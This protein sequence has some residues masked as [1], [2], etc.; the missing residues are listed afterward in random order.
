MKRI[1]H[2]LSFILIIITL[3]CSAN[4]DYSL[5]NTAK[6]HFVLLDDQ[7]QS[8]VTI[9]TLAFKEKWQWIGV[10]QKQDSTTTN[11][12]TSYNY[13]LDDKKILWALDV[14]H[15]QNSLIIDNKLSSTQAVPLTYIALA[16]NPSDSLKN[17]YIVVTDN[18]KKTT[19]LTIPLKVK[20]TKK[21]TKMELFNSEKEKK[22]T[23]LFPSPINIHH[24]QSSR[25]KLTG[26]S[27]T[28]TQPQQHSIKLLAE[29][30]I[31]F[32]K[33]NNDVPQQTKHANWFPFSPK[34]SNKKGEIGLQDWL[35]APNHVLQQ[36]GNGVKENNKSYKAWGTNVEYIHV[37]P[38]RKTA[39]KRTAFFAKYGIN[40][41][42]LH[43]LS[44][45]GWEGLGSTNKASEY[46]RKSMKR[47]DYWLS[48][49]KKNGIRYGFSPIWDLRVYEGDRESLIAY[50]ELVKAKPNKPVTSG[51]VWFAEDIQQLHI[52]TLTNLLN[53]QNPHTKKRYADDPALT[54][55]EIQNEENVFFYTF[56][57]RVK[58][59]PTYHKMLA[60]QFSDWLTKKY[61]NHSGLITAWG[62]SAIDTFR[63]EGGLP[64][65][66][67][68]LRNITPVTSPW[69][70]D[71]QAHNNR[72]A[73]RLQ[74]T[75]EFLF[76]KQQQYYKK[77][78]KAI[79]NT[80]FKGLIVS[81]N[82]QA[83]DKGAHFLNLLSDSGTGIVDRH[84]YQGGAKGRPG[85]HMKSGFKL[86]NNLMLDNPGSGLLSTGMQQVAN[87]PFM[88]SEWLS[89][90]PSEWAAADTS[91]IAAY[92]FGLQG[93]DLSYHFASNGDG[94]SQELNPSFFKFNNLTPVGVGLYPVL[95]RMVLRQDITEADPIATRRLN[96]RQAITNDYDFTHT[97]EQQHDIKS[98]SGTPSHHA[99]AAGKVLVE[100][101]KE[102][103]VSTIDD[104]QKKY[105]RKND[106]GSTTI[107]SS[108]KQ[109]AWTYAEK[110][111]GF[112]EVN[113]KGTQG[114]IGF[115]K[116]KP[117]IMDD[118]TIQPQ[119]PYSVI[120]ATA[121]SPQGT[122]A[123]DKDIIVLAIARA[124]NTNMNIVGDLITNAGEAPVILEPVKA[125]L[126]FKRK[127]GT[128]HVLD[129]D[130]IRTGKNYPLTNGKFDLDTERDKTIYYLVTFE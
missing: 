121:K 33:H 82:W 98:F 100:F 52:D 1:F 80:G 43:K 74:D 111:E 20:N 124:H 9:S 68:H 56:M 36:K 126:Q 94:F 35:T 83:G 45:S 103:G 16:V 76:L 67:L 62:A 128:V 66:Q 44:N 89:V 92:G 64:N 120:L 101:T 78:T 106:N 29:Q 84:N 59:Y 38:N 79:R 51:L 129:H 53:H 57:S 73:K 48:L 108:T 93:W 95:S 46:D 86:I 12:R 127:G 65:E 58:K 15:T 81:S 77:A 104:W 117:Y 7:H 102:R 70:H 97:T 26:D 115:A 107:T 11:K 23:L 75:A 21:I 50:D 96:K 41:V 90:V 125:Q 109:L 4:A 10:E 22:L 119:S 114:I 85:H 13:I 110:K 88:F 19:R 130:G 47:F 42:R 99:L 8:I 63:N 34:N 5:I 39:K 6:G 122:L 54:Y 2:T 14:D 71:H 30:P 37:A 91:I 18:K 55:I 60:E 40:N 87:K 112:V 27:I 72:R 28:P 24:H 3:S 69:F 32:Y 123:S 105:Q 49:L 25:I 31:R 116:D 118:L 17:G 61:K 113:S